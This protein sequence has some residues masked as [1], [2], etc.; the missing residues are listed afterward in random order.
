MKLFHGTNTNFDKFDMSRS[1]QGHGSFL[2]RGIYFSSDRGDAQSYGKFVREVEVDVDN[3]LD[4]RN[5]SA[6]KKWM[7]M[8]LAIRLGWTCV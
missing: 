5:A 2:G 8:S 1:G 3:F 4:L 6:S 7:E